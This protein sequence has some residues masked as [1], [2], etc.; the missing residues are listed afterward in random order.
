LASSSLP[1]GAF[2]CVITLELVRAASFVRDEKCGVTYLTAR[3]YELAYRTTLRFENGDMLPITAKLFGELNQQVVVRDA[4]GK[5]VRVSGYT[6]GRS[7]ISDG[8]GNL[9][10]EGRYYDSRVVQTLAG[11]DALTL[12][13]QRI[14][15]HWQNGLGRGAFAGHAFSV[16]GRLTRE[17]AADPS[18]DA[19]GHID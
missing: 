15:D 16:G 8:T 2:T 14:V 7:E 5:P 9:I 12:T 1:Q 13:G 11:D 10:F 18:G 19:H 3:D 4:S 6:Q 17:G